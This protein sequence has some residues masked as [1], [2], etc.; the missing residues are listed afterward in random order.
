MDDFDR[1]LTDASARLIGGAMIDI[2]K[3]E[4]DGEVSLVL[5]SADVVSRS[6]IQLS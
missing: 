1:S 4:V 6:I 3:A 2:L 5:D